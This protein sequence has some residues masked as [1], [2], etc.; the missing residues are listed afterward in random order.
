MHPERETP[1]PKEMEEGFKERQTEVPESDIEKLENL[2]VQ[3]KREQPQVSAGLQN[4]VQT[5]KTKPVQI[6]IPE[7]EDDLKKR[8]KGNIFDAL[9]W[10][11]AA[12]LR[13]IKKA[14]FFGKLITVRP[15]N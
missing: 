9:T 3:V 11:A 7:P 10:W 12:W 8:K 6:Q 14:R 13:A 1:V 2:N 15:K 4:V 5:T